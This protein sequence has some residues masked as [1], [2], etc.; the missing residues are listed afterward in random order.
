M[1]STQQETP[2]VFS[3]PVLLLIVT[4]ILIFWA[5]AFVM[6]IISALPP[7]T[8]ITEAFVDALLLSIIAVPIFYFFLLR[9]IQLHIRERKLIEDELGDHRL[10]LEEVV[11]RRTEELKKLNDRLED[12]ITGSNNIKADIKKRLDTLV[13]YINEAGS[14]ELMVQKLR[15][16]IE[17][18][19]S[20][21][22]RDEK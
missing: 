1:I 21:L 5:E 9:P 20:D 18:I 8:I 11:K 14:S 3:S 17:N 10:H 2:K 19:K 7:L 4:V 12:E 13:S 15:K 6:I 16:E 22:D